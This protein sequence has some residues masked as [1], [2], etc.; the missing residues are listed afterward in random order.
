MS[1][2]R[3]I[4]AG[5]AIAVALLIA[6]GLGQHHGTT[7]AA[8]S[9]KRHVL[10]YVD[11]MHPAY[12]S[13]KPGVAPDCGMQLEP[14]YSD[15]THRVVFDLASS[16]SPAGAVSVDESAQRLLGI[17]VVPAEKSGST[18]SIHAVGRVVP[19]DV[20]IYRINSGLDGF[21]R[22]TFDD[23][24]GNEVKKD[25][26]LATYYSPDFLAVASG[27]LAASERVPGSVGTD[28]AKSIPFPGTIA[29][30][31]LSSLQGYMDRL[32]NLGMSDAQI[33]HV[34]ETRQL[35]ESIEVVSPSDGFI[36]SRN[37]SSGQH[38]EHGMEF[39]KVADLAQVWVVAEVSEQQAANLRP[40]VAATILLNEEG[41]KLPAKVAD[42][43]PESEV[44]GGTVN[45]RLEADNP[46]FVLRPE[47]LVDVELPSHLPAGLTVPLDALV[48][49]G[50]RARV[51]VERT[52]GVFEPREVETGWRTADRVEI[53]KGLQAGERVVASATFLIDSESR[54]ASPSLDN[55][56]APQPSR[57]PSSTASVVARDNRTLD[58]SCGMPV[59]REQAKASGNMISL[60]GTT[61]YFCSARCKDKFRSSPAASL[62]RRSG[63]GDD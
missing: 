12:K 29:K 44:G 60:G 22:E 40:G 62:N 11:P 34:A 26:K 50:A 57:T 8:N 33:R 3:K 18:H 30:Q 54:L 25:Q 20:R 21:I 19:E 45:L 42:S 39:Y 9:A 2:A 35:P 7:K 56:A 53:V 37:I 10:Y 63:V 36:I 31:G 13:D 55:T 23:S 14:V 24:V 38:F 5:A 46:K 16:L 28:G 51:Y 61:Y 49:S 4:A 58:P 52:A 32:R 48:D 47:M 41:K 59:D 17:R 43:L 6:Y 27:F 15:D 1:V